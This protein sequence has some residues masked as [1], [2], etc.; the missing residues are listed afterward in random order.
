MGFLDETLQPGPCPLTGKRSGLAGLTVWR[1]A[2][3]YLD[4]SPKR[5]WPNVGF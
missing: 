3:E 4:F 5:F 1:A 2:N